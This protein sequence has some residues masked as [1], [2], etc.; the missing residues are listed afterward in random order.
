MIR[1]LHIPKVQTVAM[2]PTGCFHIIPLWILGEPTDAWGELAAMK[3]VH[4]KK[5]VIVDLEGYFMIA[6]CRQES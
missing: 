2:N 5:G 3:M 1:L 6:V 4:T